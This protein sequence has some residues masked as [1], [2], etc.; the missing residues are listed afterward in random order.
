M[1]NLSEMPK[2]KKDT[3]VLTDHY[4]NTPNTSLLLFHFEPHPFASSETRIQN[5]STQHASLDGKSI[6]IFDHFFSQSEGEEMQNFSKKATFSRN[7]YGSSEAIEKGEK[8]ARSMN[9]KERWKF[10]SNPP[11]AMNEVY[12]L[13]GMLAHRMDAEITTL[14]WELCDQRSHGSPSVIGNFLEEASNESMELGKHQDC[15]PEKGIPF[16]IPILYSKENQ[17]HTNCF[18]NGDLG[19][20]WLISVMLYVT[21]EEF[22]P[23]YRLGTVFYKSNGELALRTSCLNMR[24]VLFEGDIFHSIEESTI[25]SPIQTW[26]VSYV[27]KLLVNPRQKDKSMKTAFS[28]LFPLAKTVEPDEQARA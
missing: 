22:L 4:Y 23:E 3:A 17:F 18:A 1:T 28:G 15:N 11:Q 10:F 5:C 14:P 21:A 20:P 27:F 24:L 2:I 26:R 25:P 6:Y 19:K 9:G 7:S 12:K 13:F 16:G 8:A